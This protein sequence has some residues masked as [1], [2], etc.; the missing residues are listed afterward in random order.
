MEEADIKKLI[1]NY[2]KQMR[3]IIRKVDKAREKQFDIED[4]LRDQIVKVDRCEND[5]RDIDKKIESLNDLLLIG[6]YADKCMT[7]THKKYHFGKFLDDKQMECLNNS[8]K[9]TSE[10]E[11][12]LTS[13][14]IYDIT[15]DEIPQ[16]RVDLCLRIMHKIWYHGYKSFD[17]HYMY[18]QIRIFD[19]NKYMSCSY[20]QNITIFPQCPDIFS[21]F[22]S[23][24]PKKM[25][26]FLTVSK[27]FNLNNLQCECGERCT[28]FSKDKVCNRFKDMFVELEANGVRYGDYFPQIFDNLTDAVDI[29]V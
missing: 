13:G 25:K 5:M 11:S 27:L 10:M 8:I 4:A 28:F 3:K 29:V 18:K 15:E 24:Y 23:K 2:S 12:R 21:K 26:P 20:S 22:L 6:E 7:L 16:F 14:K 17:T 9:I 19:E 1:S